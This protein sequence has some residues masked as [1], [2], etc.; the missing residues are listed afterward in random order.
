MAAMAMLRLS[1]LLGQNNALSFPSSS[2]SSSPKLQNRSFYLT[3]PTHLPQRLKL[4]FAGG[5]GEDGVGRGGGGVAVEVKV[6]VIVENPKIH[7]WG[8]WVSF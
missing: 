5:G 2:S 8:F 4:S 3:N 6:G 1:P 7:L